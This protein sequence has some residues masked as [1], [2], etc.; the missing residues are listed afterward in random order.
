MK[1]RGVQI[2]GVLTAFDGVKAE[3]VS[4]AKRL[5]GPDSVTIAQTVGRRLTSV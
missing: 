3:F 1:H 2:G 5:T 4:G